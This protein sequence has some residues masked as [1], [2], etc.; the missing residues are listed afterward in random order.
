MRTAEFALRKNGMKCVY[1]ICYFNWLT[2]LGEE[3]NAKIE[4]V[5]F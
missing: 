5:K 1:L 4:E 3:T 2:L